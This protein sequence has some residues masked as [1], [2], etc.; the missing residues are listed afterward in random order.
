[1]GSK[2]RGVTLLGS[3]SLRVTHCQALSAEELCLACPTPLCPL[4]PPKPQAK[5]HFL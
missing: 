2:G 5:G 4:C 3:D 1:M